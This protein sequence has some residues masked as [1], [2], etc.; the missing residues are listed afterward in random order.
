LIYH[1]IIRGLRLACVLFVLVCAQGCLVPQSIEPIVEAPHPAPHFVLE[2]IPTYLITPVL[3]LVRQGSLDASA[4][5]PCHCFLQIPSL[6][7]HEDDPTVDL[8]ARWFLDYDANLL[9]SQVII[10]RDI[11]GKLAG[12]FNDPTLTQRSV[13]E[14]DFDADER[15]INTN[16]LHKLEVIVGETAAFDDTSAAALP[17]RTPKAG[18]ALAIYAFTINVDVQQD[19]ANCPQRLPSVRVCQ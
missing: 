13:P 16:G 19:R 12:T 7:V 9:G 4:N 14:F 6:V 8:E 15:S 3:Q 1:D 5:P 18:F 10:H 17:N 2:S 11:G